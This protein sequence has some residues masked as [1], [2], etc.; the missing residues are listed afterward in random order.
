MPES[1][2]L[3]RGDYTCVCKLDEA[4]PR[5]RFNQQCERALSAAISS[6]SDADNKIWQ[7][8]QKQARRRRAASWLFEA[9]NETLTQMLLRR[10]GIPMVVLLGCCD[11]ESSSGSGEKMSAGGSA[12]PINVDSPIRLRT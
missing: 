12:Q 10:G 3:A 2:Q 4:K 8:L 5:I 11:A 7:K 6:V 1:L 9:Y